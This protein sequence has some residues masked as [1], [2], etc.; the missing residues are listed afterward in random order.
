MNLQ[1]AKP[2]NEQFIYIY[3]KYTEFYAIYKI[4]HNAF[5]FRIFI[6]ELTFFCSAYHKTCF[7]WSNQCIF[8]GDVCLY[9]RRPVDY[10]PA[11]IS[12]ARQRP[13]C[14]CLKIRE[15]QCNHRHL[16]IKIQC[17]KDDNVSSYIAKNDDH[18]LSN[19][20]FARVPLIDQIKLFI[21]ENWSP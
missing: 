19:G 14:P 9:R 15:R 7:S 21:A 4:L 18:L 11:T 8:L 20:S 3:S 13:P 17:L 1:L 12:I 5:F 6:N 10:H 2:N 16:K